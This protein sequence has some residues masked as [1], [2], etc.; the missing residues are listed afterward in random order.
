[1]AVCA[2]LIGLA[3]AG[4][5]LDTRA[6]AQGI[7]APAT[8]GGTAAASDAAR[9]PELEAAE[10]LLRAGDF[11][12]ARQKLNEAHEKNPRLAAPGVML[13][14]WYLANNQIALA[15]AELEQVVE[16]LPDEP[17]AYGLLGELAWRDRRIAETELLFRESLARAQSIKTSAARK[18]EAEAQARAGLATVAEA[19]GRW[20][21]ARDELAAWIKLDDTNPNPHQRLGQALFHLGKPKEA[22]TEF[23]TAAKANPEFVPEIALANLYEA[24]GDRENATKSMDAASKRLPKNV[25]VRLAIANWYLEANRVARAKTQ[26]EVALNLDPDSLEAKILA[27]GIARLQKDFPA[28]ER[29]LE[30]A[31]L[32]SPTS[33]P[34]SN[35]LA[36]TLADQDDPAKKG[37]A[38]EFARQNAEKY[39]QNSEALTTLGWACFRLGRWDEASRALNQALATGALNADGAYF[40]AKSFEREGKTADAKT[41]LEKAIATKRTFAYQQD[42]EQLI[43]RLKTGSASASTSPSAKAEA[44]AKIEAPAKAK[45]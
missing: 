1:M 43:A 9:M 4:A 22:F 2:L 45:K 13:A 25:A 6:V 27:G 17:E 8:A 10:A 24:A 21:T 42:A 33:F 41:L 37:R 18:T 12:A 11:A 29:Y 5:P 35:L 31:H 38:L 16:T 44:P 32:Q 30:A 28:A 3:L 40:L 14:R 7:V 20:D 23:Q 39:P 34:A 19:R 15:R 36:L 26:V